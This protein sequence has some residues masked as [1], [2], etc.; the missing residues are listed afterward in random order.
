MSNKSIEPV[1]IIVLNWN[2]APDTITCV[3][4]LLAQTYTNL[5]IVIVDNSSTDDSVHVLH[6]YIKKNDLAATI[7]VLPNP[8]NSGFA[9][10]INHGMHHA[11]AHDFSYI[12][13]LNPDAT[14]DASWVEALVGGM[15]KSNDIGI[16]GGKLIHPDTHIIDSTGE[17][18]SK[19][20]LA[21]PMNRGLDSDRAP[22]DGFYPFGITGGAVLYRA[23][24][25]REIGLFD[26]TFFMYYEDVDL[27]FRSQLCGHKAYY[28]PDAIAYHRHGA[29]ADKVPGLTVYQT[30]KNL[31]LLFIKNVPAGL[32]FPIGIRFIFAYIMMLGNAITHG[33][34][35][36]AIKGYFKSIFLFWS[37]A[38][39]ARWSIQKNKKVST[40]YIKGIIWP[41]LPP[42]QTGLR[43]LRHFF[44]GK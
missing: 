36:W 29:S 19:W 34:G 13:T 22:H 16:S 33:N 15:K 41:D 37:S 35:I 12:G 32:L 5:S 9:G 44:T 27:S 43:K 6:D 23:S 7:T 17:A 1:A 14:A 11:L 42:E 40:S 26:P 30:F 2:C 38:L 4:S 28:C 18:Y 3:E 8:V 10:G 31:P 25:L 20:G 39:P 21:F 24:L